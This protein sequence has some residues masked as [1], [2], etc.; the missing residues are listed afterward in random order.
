M[1]EKN[2]KVRIS[3]F[4][5]SSDAFQEM[6][7]RFAFGSTRWKNIEF[8]TDDSYDRLVILTRPYPGFSYDARKALTLL[9]EPPSSSHVMAHETAA[10]VPVYLPLPFWREMP[11]QEISLISG[12]RIVKTALLSVVAS[13]LSEMEGHKRRL[14][15]VCLLDNII[16]SGL[17]V[18]G[19]PC[20]LQLLENLHAYRGQLRNKYEALWPFRYH[21]ACENSFVENYYTEKIADPIIAESLC[22][23]DGCTNLESFIDGRAF[24]RIDVKEPQEAVETI[25]RSISDNLWARRVRYIRQQK[26]RLLHQLNPLNIMWM[27]VNEM[28]V[29]K[30]C[31]L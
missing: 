5:E 19:R 4:W 20:G 3:C 29:Y 12:R 18:W 25:V 27:A 8:V 7:R 9:T 16:N 13:E 14:E 10:I 15:M 1:I 2:I 6:V 23:Y 11:D 28:D 30:G 24:V 26:Q 21:F 17:D 22:F 31:L